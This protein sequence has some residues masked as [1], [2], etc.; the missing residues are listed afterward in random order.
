LN[1][2]QSIPKGSFIHTGVWIA[3]RS[4]LSPIGEVMGACRERPKRAA[5]GETKV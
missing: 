1:L 2:T 4:K 3:D 5:R